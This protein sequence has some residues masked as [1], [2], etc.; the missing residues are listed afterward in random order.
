MG[1]GRPKKLAVSLLAHFPLAAMQPGVGVIV[2]VGFGIGVA[3][4]VAVAVEVAVAVNVAVAVAVGAGVLD[5]TGVLL[6]G[7]VGVGVACAADPPQ[8]ASMTKQITMLIE[9]IVFKTA[10]I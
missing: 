8:P 10:F 3:V 4:T 5:G 2:F 7:T 9:M 6:G 1:L